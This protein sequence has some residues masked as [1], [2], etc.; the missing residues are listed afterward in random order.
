MEIQWYVRWEEQHLNGL[1]PS[2]EYDTDL[3]FDGEHRLSQWLLDQGMYVLDHGVY[4]RHQGETVQVGEV[5]RL[6]RMGD[7]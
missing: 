4:V 2:M 7:D 3:V 1:G 5:F 6:R